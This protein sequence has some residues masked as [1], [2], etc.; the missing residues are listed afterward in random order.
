MSAPAA[1]IADAGHHEPSKFHYFVALAMILAVITGVEVVLVYL[2]LAKWFVVSTLCILSA[3]NFMCVIFIF[4]H[5]RW[6]KVFC[7]ILFF[8]GLVLAGATMWALLKLF[9]AEA[10]RPLETTMAQPPAAHSAAWLV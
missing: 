3:F 1:A 5:L 6:D 2:P 4:M 8:I 10:A 7:T 9:G